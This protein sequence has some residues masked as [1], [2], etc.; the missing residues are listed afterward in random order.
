M[1]TTVTWTQDVD[2]NYEVSSAE[3]LKQIMHKGTLYADAGSSPAEYWATGNSFK[4]TADIDLMGDSTDIK[5]IGLYYDKFYGDYDGGE[6]KIS[7]WS[8]VDPNTGSQCE[9]AVGLFGYCTQNV[10]KNIR[11]NGLWT[12]QGYTQ[13]AGFL[14]GIQTEP[15]QTTPHG[16]WNIEC[17]FSDGSFIENNGYVASGSCIGGVCGNGY[18]PVA[19]SITLKGFVDFRP[20]TSATQKVGGVFG[21]L[22][23]RARASLVQNLAT[24]P[25]GINGDDYTGGVCGYLNVFGSADAT[26]TG[27]LNAMIGDLRGSKYVGGVVGFASNTSVNGKFV[28][29]INSMTG[30]I[31][32]DNNNCY[33]GGIMGHMASK[34]QNSHFMNYMTGFIRDSW[35]SGGLIAE[36]SWNYSTLTSSINAMNSIN[37]ATSQ[38]TALNDAIVDDDGG[39]KITATIDT[40]FGLHYRNASD[41]TNAAPTDVLYAPGFPDL[42]YVVLG[43]GSTEIDFVFGNLSAST[44]Y[45]SYTHCVLHK[46]NIKGPLKV[47]FD[48]PEN[49]TTLYATF[50][51]YATESVNA[52]K[53]TNLPPVYLALRPRPINVSVTVTEVPGATSYNMTYEGPTGTE[54]S[55]IS[56]VTSLEHSIVGLVPDTEYTIRLYADTGSGYELTQESVTTTLPNVATNYNVADFVKEGVI[57][58]TSFDSTTRSRVSSVMN[59]LLNTGDKVR[60]PVK[61]KPEFETSFVGLGDTLSIAGVKGVL[62][63]F[64]ESTGSGQGV[65]LVLTDG[66]TSGVEYDEQYDT[67]TVDGAVYYPGDSFVLDGQK[68]TVV[69]Y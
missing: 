40:N 6:F 48:I 13:Y 27:F 24:F 20:N 50:I 30:N 5:P 7:N 21:Q 34:Y 66:S 42:P 47:D 56:G 59:E 41:F 9:K 36:C 49:S 57:D 51:N 2:S 26:A 45:D 18:V 38:H 4:Q 54:V 29:M 25:S 10:L 44:S 52:L 1:A 43:D 33:L 11:L 22:A 64:D 55:A 32:G 14:A 8:Y 69:T 68:T 53:T 35:R 15:D 63:P 31:S 46:G 3:H 58:L 37:A 39:C 16:I 17:D 60:L 67:I 28:N 61:R 62:L 23:V 19:K 65:G 12:L